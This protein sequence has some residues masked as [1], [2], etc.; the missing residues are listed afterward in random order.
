MLLSR[1]TQ[2]S[3]PA[4]LD[5][6]R[7]AGRPGRSCDSAGDHLVHKTAADVDD[8]CGSVEWPVSLGAGE[9]SAIVWSNNSR[10]FEAP[11]APAFLHRVRGSGTLIP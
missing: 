11:F 1:P 9:W 6:F 2:G 8:A 7:G 3:P 10:S 4:P 5:G